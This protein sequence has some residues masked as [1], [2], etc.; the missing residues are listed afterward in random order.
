MGDGEQGRNQG[1]LHVSDV[2]SS[3]DELPSCMKKTLGTET[4]G[5]S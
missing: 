1:R 3:M 4:V 2:S 5:R